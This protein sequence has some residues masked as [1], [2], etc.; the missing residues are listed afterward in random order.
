MCVQQLE[1]W[2]K[3]GFLNKA[4]AR[5]QADLCVCVC[6]YLRILHFFFQVPKVRPMTTHLPVSQ[7][8][9]S[10]RA[11]WPSTDFAIGSPFLFLPNNRLWFCDQKPQCGGRW[12]P[13]VFSDD[14]FATP[15]ARPGNRKEGSDS[16]NGSRPH[17]K[18]T[19]IRRIK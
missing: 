8:W 6:V 2:A 7:T 5:L 3:C 15:S 11:F 13:R 16:L 19:I 1:R 18:I 9:P 17:G 12:R 14:S 10:K 4:S